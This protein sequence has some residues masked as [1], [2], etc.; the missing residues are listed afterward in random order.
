MPGVLKQRPWALG[1]SW[2]SRSGAPAPSEIGSRIFADSLN[3]C[4]LEAMLEEAR[5]RYCP[6]QLL[7]GESKKELVKN[8][9]DVKPLVCSAVEGQRCGPPASVIK[10]LILPLGEEHGSVNLR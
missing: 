1:P 7:A 5:G 2:C 10:Q 3:T 8:H 9:R 6:S 4:C